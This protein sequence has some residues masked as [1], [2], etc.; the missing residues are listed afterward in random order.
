[1]LLSLSSP[2]NHLFGSSSS[3]ASPSLLNFTSTRRG[4]SILQLASLIGILAYL[5]PSPAGRL[6]LVAV[7]NIIGIMRQVVTWSGI[8]S[9]DSDVGY[10]AIGWYLPSVR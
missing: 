1:M 4:Q 6:A 5:V 8:V 2:H 3:N 9:G 7:A 10:Q